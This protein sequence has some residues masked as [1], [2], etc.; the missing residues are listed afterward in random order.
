[1]T[2][3][4]TFDDEKKGRGYVMMT[5]GSQDAYVIIFNQ[6]ATPTHSKNVCSFDDEEEGEDQKIKKMMT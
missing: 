1:M 2:F 6:K 4:E 3:L 5:R